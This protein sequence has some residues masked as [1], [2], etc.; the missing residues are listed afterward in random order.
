MMASYNPNVRHSTVRGKSGPGRPTGRPNKT[1]GLAKDNIA[2]TFEMLGGV[3]GLLRWAKQHPKEFYCKVYPRLVPVDVQA[4]K[5]DE[6]VKK[7]DNSA[8][9]ALGRIFEGIFAARQDRHA[10]DTVVNDHD[11]DAGAAPELVRTHKSAAV[12][13]G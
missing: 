4:A 3:E 6:A 11:P 7:E 5:T 2:E 10:A 9:E 13:K 1:T 12:R 8:R